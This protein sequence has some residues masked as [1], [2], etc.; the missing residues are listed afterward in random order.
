ME[1]EYIAVTDNSKKAYVTLQVGHGSE[2]SRVNRCD[3]QSLFEKRK[4]E[5]VAA[6]SAPTDSRLTV[7]GSDTEGKA[8]EI[9]VE[10][11]SWYTQFETL[12][13]R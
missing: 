3:E 10:N 12:S 1:P 4:S 11:P 7:I 13:R 2:T 9:T 5:G 8:S 6:S